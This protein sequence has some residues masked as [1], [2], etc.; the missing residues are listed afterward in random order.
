MVINGRFRAADIGGDR[1]RG[2]LRGLVARKRSQH[3]GNVLRV[4]PYPVEAMQVDATRF[5]EETTEGEQCLFGA[6]P[7]QPRPATDRYALG[8]VLDR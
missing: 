5:I 6:A 4:A 7:Q 8:D 1:T 3:A 2:G